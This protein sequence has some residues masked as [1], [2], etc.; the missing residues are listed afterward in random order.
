MKK[1]STRC[2]DHALATESAQRIVTELGG[3]NSEEITRTEAISSHDTWISMSSGCPSDQDY[4]NVLL[5][6]ISKAGHQRHTP[7]LESLWEE[8]QA[9]LKRSSHSSE[10]AE[11]T[12]TIYRRLLM[13]LMVCK[14]PIMA[15]EIWNS[16]LEQGIDPGKDHWDAMAKECGVAGD[17]HSLQIMWQK[18]LDAGIQ[19]DAQLWGTRIEGLMLNGRW[20]AGLE[21]FEEMARSWLHFSQSRKI[22]GTAPTEELDRI[23]KPNT[24]CL[25]VTIAGL[26]KAKKYEPAVQVLQQAKI[27]KI[28]P[29]IYSFNPILRSEIHEERPSWLRS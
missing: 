16:M 1:F 17:P 5:R 7:H 15:I 11:K 27:L 18:M 24:E 4:L 8:A 29:D 3:S 9:V 26:V 23:P 14:K 13:A 12:R 28:K 2:R 20:L 6:R 10:A 21:A 19:P 25:N 22:R